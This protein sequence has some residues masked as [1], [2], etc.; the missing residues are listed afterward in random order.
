M[1][2]Q[3]EQTDRDLERLRR[4]LARIEREFPDLRDSPARI[5]EERRALEIM[6][7]QI[8]KH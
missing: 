2:A 1:I 7:A 8:V 6:I 5:K 4:E 3:I